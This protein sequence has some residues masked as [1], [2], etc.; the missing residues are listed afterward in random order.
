[1]EY[2]VVVML[3]ITKLE[4]DFARNVLQI[5]F[6]M[7][8]LAQIAQSVQRAFITMKLKNVVK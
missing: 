6:G 4:Q 1:M 5:Q 7:D 2:F 3:N 8:I